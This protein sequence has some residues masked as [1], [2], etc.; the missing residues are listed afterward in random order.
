MAVQENIMWNTIGALTLLAPGGEHIVP[1]L[2]R[3]C[4]FLCKYAYELV[5]KTWLFSVMSLEKGST[6]FTP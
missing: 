5:E 4:V 6:L 1:P 3:I 2:L